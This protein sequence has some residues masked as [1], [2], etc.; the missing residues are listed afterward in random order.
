MLALLRGLSAHQMGRVDIS[1]CF[2]LGPISY[3][4]LNALPEKGDTELERHF[5][6]KIFAEPA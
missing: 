4:I 1:I 3:T 2:S 5:S 6:G